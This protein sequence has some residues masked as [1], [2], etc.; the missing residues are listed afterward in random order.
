MD[1]G[2]HLAWYRVERGLSQLSAKELDELPTVDAMLA[3]V[4]GIPVPMGVAD[5]PV[6]AH[7]WTIPDTGGASKVQMRAPAEHRVVLE[8]EREG[9][10]WRLVT[11]RAH[12]R[13][14]A[15]SGRVPE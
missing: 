6:L 12:R 8:Y 3:K 5:V 10:S 9:D 1:V 2:Y 11:D 13:H 4:L 14:V 15:R 7:G